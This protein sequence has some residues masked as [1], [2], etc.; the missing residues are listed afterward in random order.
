MKMI[1]VWFMLFSI[2]LFGID[3]VVHSP[4][5]SIYGLGLS[6]FLFIIAI[7]EFTN[8]FYIQLSYDHA[9]DIKYLMRTKKCKRSSLSKDFKRV[10]KVS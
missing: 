9:A 10:G 5:L 3:I 1:N 6:G 4:S 8:Y 7:L 2:L